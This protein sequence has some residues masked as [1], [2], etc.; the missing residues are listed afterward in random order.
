M[1]LGVITSLWAYAESLSIVETFDRIANLGL[2]HVDI[3]GFLHGDPLKLSDIEKNQIR[4]QVNSLSL[5][6]GSLIMLPP[7]N[8][9]SIDE[10]ENKACWEYVRAGIDLIA[11]LGGKQVLFN[12]GKRAFGVPHSRSW[13]NAVSFIRR[14]SSYAQEKDVFVTVEAEPY[15]YFLVN[16]LDTT[17]RMVRDVDHPHCMTALDIG[18]MNLSR[19]AP[20]TLEVVKAWTMRI[21]LSENDGLLHANDIHGTGNVDTGTYLKVLE[22]TNFDDTC[23]KHNMDLVAVMEL[24][25]LGDAIPDPDD[26][27]RQSMRHLLEVAP[28]LEI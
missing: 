15:V 12:G 1:K 26:F 22:S 27:A 23:K 2:R 9:A 19:D 8:I 16:D 3:L 4:E 7:G 18:H 28:F 21:H 5:T 14:A 20:E 6:L 24:G 25:V 10:N 11:H 13:E 17:V